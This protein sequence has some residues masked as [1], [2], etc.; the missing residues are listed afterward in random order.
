MLTATLFRGEK[1]KGFSSMG[2]HHQPHAKSHTWEYFAE[3]V[4]ENFVELINDISWNYRIWEQR[5]I[6]GGG[7][8]RGEEK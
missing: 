1:D 7:K 3:W 6:G 8:E 5:T 2:K 4:H